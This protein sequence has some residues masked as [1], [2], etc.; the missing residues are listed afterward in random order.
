MPRKRNIGAEEHAKSLLEAG[1]TYKEILEI[2]PLSATTLARINRERKGGE[3]TPRQRN[4]VV[5]TSIVEG[6]VQKYSP[7]EVARRVRVPL[8]KVLKIQELLR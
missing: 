5:R 4:E 7:Q 1:K 3:V 8:W 6:F 2:L